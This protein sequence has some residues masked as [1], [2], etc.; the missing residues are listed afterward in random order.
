[1]RSAAQRLAAV[2]VVAAL[3]VFSA[4]VRAEDDVAKDLKALAG[5]W[6]VVRETFD[7]EE[8]PA[9]V[10]EKMSLIVRK[11]LVTI[12]GGLAKAGDRFIPL[13]SQTPYKVSLGASAR[14][15]T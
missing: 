13:A 7:G 1:M 9:E 6:K 12:R 15:K 14:P 5:T 4:P 11:E 10:A 8:V 2:A 3:A